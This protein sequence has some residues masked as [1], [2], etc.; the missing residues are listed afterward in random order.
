MSIEY[1]YYF[2]AIIALFILLLAWLYANPG[3]PTYQPTESTVVKVVLKQGHGSGVS[4]GGGYVL[5]AAHV[6]K[7]VNT[8]TLKTKD[9]KTREA[10]VLWA[11]TDYDVAL[12]RTSDTKLEAAS[13]DCRIAPEGASIISY[14]NPLQVEFAAAYGRI[15]GSPRKFGPWHSVF[16]TD[17]TT[18]MGQSGGPVFDEDGK[19]IGLTVGVM[20]APLGFSMSLVG[21]GFV[22]PSRTVCDLLARAEGTPA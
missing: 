18:V 11:N 16:V 5:T 13:L 21:Y 7:G 8:V 2:S 22:V 3:L 12:L 14:G 17:I 6:V 20:G 9:G 15:A 10:D 1:R 19:L 4:I